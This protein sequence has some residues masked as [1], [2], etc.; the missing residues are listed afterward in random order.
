MQH[1]DLSEIGMN[2]RQNDGGAIG[3]ILLALLLCGVF[4]LSVGAYGM[5]A[6]E[7]GSLNG[8]LPGA[9]LA[10]RE[11]V[12][13]NGTVAVFLGLSP[14]ESNEDAERAARILAAAEAYIQEKEG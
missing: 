1:T 9:V 14:V 10:L 2:A 4:F 11:L 5:F 3:V 7:G 13:E 12:E 6:E 8:D